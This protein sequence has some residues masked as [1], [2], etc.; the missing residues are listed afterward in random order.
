MVPVWKGYGSY[1]GNLLAVNNAIKK[2]NKKTITLSS[3]N[4]A[5]MALSIA[6][7]FKG[8]IATIL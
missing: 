3:V 6:K 1:M 2:N 7:L 5:G 8:Y 4:K